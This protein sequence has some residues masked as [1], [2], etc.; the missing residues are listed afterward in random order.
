MDSHFAGP[1]ARTSADTPPAPR[2]PPRSPRTP[3]R[4]SC[5]MASSSRPRLR[6]MTPRLAYRRKFI[7]NKCERD[8]SE[9]QDDCE[10]CR[11]PKPNPPFLAVL[12]HAVI[13]PAGRRGR[14][15][16]PAL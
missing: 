6:S 2:P 1:K 5:G 4:V 9:W 12:V 8:E 3:R 14:K 7:E 11:P 15:C 16:E 13:L 10:E